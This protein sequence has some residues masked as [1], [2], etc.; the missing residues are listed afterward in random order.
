[1]IDFTLFGM[2]RLLSIYIPI[3]ALLIYVTTQTSA[4]FNFYFENIIGVWIGFGS[5][6]GSIHALKKLGIDFD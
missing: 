2:Q 3:I 5:I 1:M 4:E 6:Y